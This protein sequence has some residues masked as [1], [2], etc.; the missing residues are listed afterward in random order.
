MI[1]LIDNYDSFTY[2]LYQCVAELGCE[3]KVIRNDVV[4]VKE[5]IALKCQGI[6]ISPGPGRPDESG[7][8][9]DLVLALAGKVP[10]LGVCLGH[11]VIGE[12][13]G[14][15]IV[16]I[17]RPVHGKASIIEH[18]GGALYQGIE[19]KFAAGRYHS[20][21]VEA[22]SLPAC[23][24][25]T[26]KTADGIIMGIRHREYDVEGVQFHPESVLTPSGSKLL[27]NFVSRVQN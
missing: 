15:K 8:S 17:A 7:V 4:T 27:A 6:I 22:A 19:R 20:L 25:V 14:G 11:Q 26:A 13:F 2:N 9:R 10:I 12:V 21:I 23:L 16:R 5:I 1:V 18:R 24:E 3:T